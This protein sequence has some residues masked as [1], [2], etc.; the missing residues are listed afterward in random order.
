MFMYSYCY[1]CAVLCILIHCVVLCIVFLFCVLFLCKCVLYYS[2]R[3]STQQ[4]FTNISVSVLEIL[5]IKK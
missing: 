1:V 4:Q 3:V 2:H 5:I